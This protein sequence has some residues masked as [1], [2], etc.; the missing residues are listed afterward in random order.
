MRGFTHPATLPLTG[1]V[2]ASRPSADETVHDAAQADTTYVIS[3]DRF[4]DFPEKASIRFER[5]LGYEIMDG[6]VL[7]YDLSVDVAFTKRR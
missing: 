3:N 6:R 1:H 5:I 7:V 2:V 4:T